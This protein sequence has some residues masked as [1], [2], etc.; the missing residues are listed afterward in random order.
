MN[1]QILTE[2]SPWFIPLCLVGGALYA[3]ILYYRE[4][5]NE[6][7][8]RLRWMLATFRFVAVSI[9]AFLLLSPLVKTIS[10]VKE[11]P[12]VVIA[13]DNTR[14]VVTNRDSSYYNSEYLQR[15]QQVAGQL[16]EGYE[17]KTYSFGEEVNEGLPEDFT[18][19]QT[20][21]DEL[22]E[23][24]RT[25]FTNRNV[26]ALVLASDGIYNRGM[27]PVYSARNLEFPVYTVALGDTTLPRDLI[28]TEVNSNRIAYSGNKFP[29]EA[30]VQA[31]RLKGKR[32]SLTV[33][34]EGKNLYSKE[35][36][37]TSDQFSTKVSFQLEAGEKGLKRYD[38]Q[39][40]AVGNERS[41]ANN[42]KQVFIEVLEG[43]QKI[44]LLANTPH[45]DI[46][47][48]KEAISGNFN[49]EI[50]STY[51]DEFGG[52]TEEYNL[53][54]LHQLPPGNP[55]NRRKIE[56]V[57]QA[58]I[59]VLFVIGTQTNLV[60]FNRLNT[61][62]RIVIQGDQQNEALPVVNERFA[63]FNI[64]NSAKSAVKK[65][66]PL[67]SPFADYQMPNSARVFMH[68]QIGSVTTDKPL[69]V[70]NESSG[71]KTG[72]IAGE[73]LWRWRLYNYSQ[74][75]NHEAFNEIINKMIQYLSVKEEKKR[76][77]VMAENNYLENRAVTFEAELYNA[78][79]ELVNEPEVELTIED[80]EGK[81]YPFGFSRTGNAYRLKA[82]TF[83]V[84]NYT[85]QARTTLGEE[86]FTDN[87]QFSVSPLNIETV[88]TIADHGL[89]YRL[90]QR[91]DGEML[92]PANLDQLPDMINQRD[93]VKTLSYGRE[94]YEDLVSLEWLFFVILA[95]LAFEWF[96]RKRGGAY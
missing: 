92:Y 46:K 86:V 8:A 38:V 29:M 64:S 65:Y 22:F 70:F 10:E 93:D 6:F 89:M 55:L 88:K 45:P 80:E 54:I 31:N 27:N 74:Q 75:R 20:N 90:A 91:H 48:I 42:S 32:V 21:F 57:M 73:G 49:Y 35:I 1:I 36:T 40:E 95:L 14:S 76:F 41:T 50:E 60:A 53:V 44:L 69:V 63:L 19:R 83:P 82:G 61:G 78:S 71:R 11:K 43:K 15:L 5:D 16:E 26:G 17:V 37:I 47:A 79:Y 81:Q 58:D 18:G 56:Q 12:I 34:S 66:P 68:Q 51:I 33:S 4:R 62:L 96:M 67:I 3:F 59:P 30:I 72:V 94:R 84:G 13:Q 23:S 52:N 2:Q 9:I 24:L 7:S 77:R 87:G 25:R 28:L 85:W 39:L